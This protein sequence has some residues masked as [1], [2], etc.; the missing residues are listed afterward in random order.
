MSY[1][2]KDDDSEIEMHETSDGI[3]ISLR[4]IEDGQ[5]MAGTTFYL[6][7]EQVYGMAKWLGERS[8][9]P[10]PIQGDDGSQKQCSERG[11][12]GCNRSGCEGETAK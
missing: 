12:C 5:E 9:C 10:F 2:S 11:H 4:M 3:A 8:V 6:R 7:P 1:L